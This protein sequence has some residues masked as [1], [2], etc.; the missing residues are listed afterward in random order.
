MGVKASCWAWGVD[1]AP[2]PKII[3][4]AY[5]DFANDAGT[6]WPSHDAIVR[7]TGCS[8][9]TVQRTLRE[10]E[11][12]G[13]LIVTEVDGRPNRV[14][15]NL[16]Y[17]ADTRNEGRHGDAPPVDN[18]G[19]LSTEGCHSSVTP[20]GRHGDAP[21]NEGGDTAVTRGG[22]TAVSRG[23]RHSCVTRS[24]NNHH[25]PSSRARVESAEGAA[26]DR[27]GVELG[28][29][30]LMGEPDEWF[31]RRLLLKLPSATAE[32]DLVSRGVR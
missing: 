13:L 12:L 27:I 26:L 23:G 3:L 2:L 29:R 18:R 10:F 5:A 31:R 16:S 25:D 30:R 21:P 4:L 28:D 9:R 19:D 20:G 1:L 32:G 22:D 8:R 7:M 17:E 6:A 14:Q 15:L 11:H 24:P